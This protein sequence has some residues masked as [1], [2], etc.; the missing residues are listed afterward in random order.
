MVE[1]P[2]PRARVRQ[3]S[4]Q[5]KFHLFTSSGRHDVANLFADA[6]SAP[7]SFSYMIGA[8]ARSQQLNVEQLNFEDGPDLTRDR[9]ILHSPGAHFSRVLLVLVGIPPRADLRVLLSTETAMTH[10]LISPIVNILV[11]SSPSSH[12]GEFY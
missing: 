8:Y 10:K 6:A 2:S 12:G 3:R 11:P 9:P 7:L 1:T 4:R 5:H